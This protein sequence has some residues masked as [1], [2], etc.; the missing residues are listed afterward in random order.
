MAKKDKA[1]ARWGF[2]SA[3]AA[4]AHRLS[5]I[6]AYGYSRHGASRIK[7]FGAAWRADPAGPAEDIDANVSTL[8][9]RSRD[10]YMGASIATA[11]IDTLVTAV[12]GPAL[13]L[14]AEIDHEA[15]GIPHEE[16]TRIERLCEREFS[17][18]A[19][20]KMASY[21]RRLTFGQIQHLVVL[22]ALLSGDVFVAPVYLDR[23]GRYGLTLRVIEADLVS[24]P[25]FGM[26]PE[27]ARIVEGVEL[28]ERGA[29]VAYHVAD[30]YATAPY[31]VGAGPA[32]WQ[33]IEAYGKDTGE[34]NMWHIATFERPFQVRGVPALSCVMEDIKQ[35]A[36][37]DE[38]E[39]MAA[40]VS[41]YFTGFIT[42]PEGQRL[43]SQFPPTSP[44]PDGEGG[45]RLDNISLGAGMI[46]YLDEGES[47]TFADP[48]R[49]N[50]NYAPFAEAVQ[51]RIGAALG[52]P[53]E[54][55]MKNFESSYTA[56]KGAKIEFAKTVDR[57]RETLL[58]GQFCR[59]VYEAW[60]AEAVARGH[61]KMAGFFDDPARRHAWSGSKWYGLAE[62]QLDPLKEVRA[63]KIR[64]DEG[65]S[66]R[67]R[68][69]AELTGEK[70]EELH[71]VRVREEEMRRKDGLGNEKQLELMGAS[72]DDE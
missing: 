7:Q 27:G 29:P 25:A 21:D 67:A 69:A 28:D 5:V 50:A 46:N 53:R 26:A 58:I 12:V 71:R 14:D 20:N 66:T 56:S 72:E 32:K 33:R 13:M 39:L 2:D 9:G 48:S 70:Y 37:Y 34:P 31:T 10:L 24:T 65:F 44:P 60:L 3:Y 36:R 15:L 52:T 51:R 6:E 68:E 42:S 18:W 59:P 47:I 19:Q 4:H 23:G 41:A 54:I 35:L 22:S 11:A 30:R 1:K 61:I 49:P 57:M 38:A 62:D 45:G 64:V 55:L 16:A 40:L 8:R 63:A 43:E 17:L